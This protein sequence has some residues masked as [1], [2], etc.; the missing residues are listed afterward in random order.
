MMEPTYP[1]T[2]MT[3]LAY[4]IGTWVVKL[5]LKITKNYDASCHVI[6]GN[7]KPSVKLNAVKLSLELGYREEIRSPDLQSYSQSM[8]LSWL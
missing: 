1:I 6:V 8:R 5:F 7:K 3:W 4:I 2:Y